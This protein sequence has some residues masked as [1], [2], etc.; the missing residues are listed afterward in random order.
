MQRA[1]DEDGVEVVRVGCDEGFE[2][3]AETADCARW[4]GE[5][6]LGRWWQLAA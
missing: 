4:D 1:G 5:L 2:G 3:L 6:S